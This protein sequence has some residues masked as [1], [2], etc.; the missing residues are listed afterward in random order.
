MK[1]TRIPIVTEATSGSIVTSFWEVMEVPL[2]RSPVESYELAY[3]NR[4]WEAWR[5]GK[6]TLNP[7]P[8]DG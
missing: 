3:L 6:L 8:E 1:I 2:E 7:R 5:T 4:R